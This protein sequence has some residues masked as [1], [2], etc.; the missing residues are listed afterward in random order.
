MQKTSSI[1]A[2]VEPS[3]KQ[4]AESI[5]GELGVPLS[6]AINIFLKQIVMQRGIPF[7]VKLSPAAPVAIGALDVATLDAELE[8]GY[9]DLKKGRVRTKKDVFSDV[10]QG[11]NL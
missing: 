2:R 7:E 3:L 9:A 1:F 6:N 5:L 10:K 4:E 8:K 11:Y